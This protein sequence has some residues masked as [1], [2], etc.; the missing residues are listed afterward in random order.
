MFLGV[1][2]LARPLINV[3]FIGHKI[4]NLGEN[5]CSYWLNV[6]VICYV[7]FLASDQAQTATVIAANEA[8]A[9]I[10]ECATVEGVIAKGFTSES[11][12]TF[13]NIGA[14]YPNQ[15]FTGWIPPAS[16]VNKS[17]MLSEIEGKRAK[18]TGRI[19][20]CNQKAAIRVNDPEQLA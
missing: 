6:V 12:N 19:E 1:R 14:T 4:D 7:A 5:I 15:T 3:F 8:A 16:P 18:I 2:I 9:L 13:L 10:N 11:G 17:P 20:M